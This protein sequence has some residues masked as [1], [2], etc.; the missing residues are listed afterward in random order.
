MNIA[1]KKKQLRLSMLEKRK[2]S[3]PADLSNYSAKICAALSALVLDNKAESI[4]CF[5]PIGQEV[6][7]KP[8]LSEALALG[9]TV[10]V[11]KTLKKPLLAHCLLKDLNE[12]APGLFGTWHPT[13]QHLFTGNYDL[14]VVPGLAFDAAGNRL[15]YGGGYYD[16]FLKEHPSALK[17]GVAFPFQLVDEVPCEAYDIPLDLVLS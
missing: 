11:P 5:I 1:E 6:N 8:F 16:N 15:G 9:K 3:S 13:E 7:L 10:I 12:L 17:V 2:N 14:I 4:H